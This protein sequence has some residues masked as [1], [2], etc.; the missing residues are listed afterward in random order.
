[1]RKLLDKLNSQMEMAEKK[2]EA[3]FYLWFKIIIVIIINSDDN[4]NYYCLIYSYVLK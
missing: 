2:S 3:Y 4:Y 1:M